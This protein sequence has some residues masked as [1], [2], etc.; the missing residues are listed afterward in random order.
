MQ[1]GSNIMASDSPLI[2][3]CDPIFNTVVTCD[4]V[5]SEGYEVTNLLSEDSQ[6]R[7]SGFLGDRF[8]KPPVEISL[9]FPFDVN[10]RYILIGAEVGQQKSSGLEVHSSSFPYNSS[11]CSGS[12]SSENHKRSG[13]ACSPVAERIGSINLSDS[14]KGVVFFCPLQYGRQSPN[15]VPNIKPNFIQRSM[16][17]KKRSVIAHTASLAIRIFRTHGSSV[18]AIGSLE[19]WGGPSSCMLPNQLS[20]VMKLWKTAQKEQT[21]NELEGKYNSES[22]SSPLP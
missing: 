15:P 8:I 9:K 6:K 10:I 19:I 18:P 16:M 1:I 14:E 4:T 3:L 5:S 7:K 22:C 11:L 13:L 12:T 2:N 20:D 21:P 17:W